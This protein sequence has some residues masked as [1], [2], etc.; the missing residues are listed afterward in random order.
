[1]I[2][3]GTA[4]FGSMDDDAQLIADRRM[5]LGIT[6]R[7]LATEAGVDRGTLSRIEEG[8]ANPQQLTVRKLLATLT[9]LEEES[10][11][12]ISAPPP[13]DLGMIEFEV[14]GDFGV[15]VVVRGPVADAAALEE[16]VTRLIRGMRHDE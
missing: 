3:S 9:R 16:S 14:T 1:M 11:V 10:G 4:G 5:R 8:T 12:D 6:I 7:D 15:R 2:W 13:D